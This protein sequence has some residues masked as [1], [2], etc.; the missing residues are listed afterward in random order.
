[1]TAVPLLRAAALRAI[2]R[3]AAER[4]GEP[5]MARAGRAIANLAATLARGRAG[6]IVLIAGPGNNGG[7]AWV[8]AGVLRESGAAASVW[9]VT[10]NEPP[11]PLARAARA[12]YLGHGGGRCTALPADATLVVDGLFGIGLTRELDPRARAVVAAINACGA[13]VLA[14]DVPSGLDADTGAARGDAV[15]ATHTLTF[16]AGKP[17]L[18][19]GDGPDHAGTVQLDTLGLPDEWLAEGAGELLCAGTVP[20]LPP[21]LRNTHKGTYGT[22]GVVGG[23]AG[24]AG[25]AILAARGALYAG[26]GKAYATALAPG[27]PAYDPVTPEI[28]LRGL[29]ETLAADVLVAGPG[30]GDPQSAFARE[31]LPRL[32][33]SDKPLVLDADALTA[34]AAL[35]G[36]PRANLRQRAAPTLLTPHPG[37]AARLLRI[38]TQAVQADRLGAALALAER[39]GCDVVLK[40]AGSVCASADGRWAVNASGNPGLASG[41]TGDVLAGVLGAL[42]AQGLPP[43]EAL[44]LGVWAH[45]EAADRLVAGGAGPAGLTAGELPV[46]VRRVLNGSAASPAIWQDRA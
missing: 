34:L 44:R 15:R 18:Y 6:P 16:I 13:P 40:G 19:T 31:V 25:A 4:G 22:V 17:G 24:M 32:L 5:L 20:T 23:A 45:G 27:M 7:D 29:E 37:E 11:E 8:A 28:L 42:L 38:P 21:R 26:A 9:D 2:E 10:G 3:R 1:M 14:I 41:G 33:A 43:W 35:R 46:A 12:N 36:D 39:H 30:A